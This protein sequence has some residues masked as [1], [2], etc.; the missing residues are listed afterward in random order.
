MSSE[1]SDRAKKRLKAFSGIGLG[2]NQRKLAKALDVLHNL[3]EEDVPAAWVLDK[4]RL[5]G[6]GRPQVPHADPGDGP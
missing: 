1:A 6:G 4:S 5:A 2:T 3:P